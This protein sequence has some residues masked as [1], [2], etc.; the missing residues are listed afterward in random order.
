MVS[1]NSVVYQSHEDYMTQV[2][3]WKSEGLSI[4]FTNGCFD[5]LHAGH[6]MYLKEAGALG[7]RLIVGL[8]SDSSVTRLKGPQRPIKGVEDR[9][10]VLSSLR[11]VDL[12][13][14]FDADTPIE[15][16]EKVNPD[17]LVKG[18]DYTEDEI[19][20]SSFVKSQGNEVMILSEKKGIS[21]TRIIADFKSKNE[22]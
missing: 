8:N 17:Y 14:V 20:G 7:D 18:G 21:T 11:M 15:L 9:A 5:I 1:S 16:I 22:S 2:S 3:I 19:V 13:I 12:V 10:T 4:T 6:I